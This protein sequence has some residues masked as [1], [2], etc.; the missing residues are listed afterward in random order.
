[1]A[2][3]T[4]RNK[5]ILHTLI[6]IKSL[7]LH[8]KQN[9]LSSIFQYLN[10]PKQ[11]VNS[12][13][14]AQ[15]SNNYL[16]ILILSTAYY[17]LN[18]ASTQNQEYRKAISILKYESINNKDKTT[19]KKPLLKKYIQR[20]KYKYQKYN[21]HKFKQLTECRENYKN[22]RK[23]DIISITYLYIIYK[24]TCTKN[25]FITYER[26]IKLFTSSIYFS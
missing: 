13:K 25:K 11:K 6:C 15:G 9:K 17:I 19:K 24:I 12:R 1:M 8:N 26:F 3:I 18:I 21:K 2:N 16:C 4:H 22:E 7:N 23:T 10:T 14:I 5:Q 20:F